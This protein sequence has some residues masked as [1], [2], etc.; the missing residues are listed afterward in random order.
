[1]KIMVSGNSDAVM[2]SETITAA[3]EAIIRDQTIENN[4]LRNIYV[5]TLRVMSRSIIA[6]RTLEE[7]EKVLTAVDVAR[8]RLQ[9][10]V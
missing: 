3:A 8:W 6:D 5:H 10:E 7:A 1:M 9:H 2:V 4:H